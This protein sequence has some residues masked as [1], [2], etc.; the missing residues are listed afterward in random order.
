VKRT[1]LERRTPLARGS[2]PLAR[3]GRLNPQSA[4][5]RGERD[6]RQE[7]MEQAMRGAGRQCEARSIVPEI[8]C[9]G[10]LDVDEVVPRGVRPG[11]HLD[12]SNVQVLC[13]AHHDW[14]HA[15][16]REA[17]AR[18]LRKWSWEP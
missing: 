4:K 7:V 2:K 8:D 17:Q 6:E 12:E 1:P 11:A 13:R 15:N 5:R 3:G 18:G 14:K 9:W 16:P 10:P